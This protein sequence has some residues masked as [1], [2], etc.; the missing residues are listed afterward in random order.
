VP[1]LEVGYFPD[2]WIAPGQYRY[3]GCGRYLLPDGVRVCAE[4]I[5]ADAES[6]AGCC[7]E[8]ERLMAERSTAATHLRAMGVKR[9]YWMKEATDG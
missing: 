1:S 5:G 6:V 7:K 8:H 9:L 2:D 4:C 3:C